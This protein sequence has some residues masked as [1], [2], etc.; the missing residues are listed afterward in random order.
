MQTN[1]ST[2]TTHTPRDLFLTRV[3]QG[4]MLG[5]VFAVP[6]A[7]WAYMQASPQ[8]LVPTAEP[9][10]VSVA[11][12]ARKTSAARKATRV[13]EADTIPASQMHIRIDDGRRSGPSNPE[14]VN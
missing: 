7:L 6:V 11:R 9:S 8:S 4:V 12:T 1:D 10:P 3:V 13:R 5:S 2:S 14:S